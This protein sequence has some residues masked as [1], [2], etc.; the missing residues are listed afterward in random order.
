MVLEQDFNSINMEEFKQKL[1]VLL[2]ELLNKI[3]RDD[4]ILVEPSSSRN[5]VEQSQAGRK[6]K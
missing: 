1:G 5:E 6:V 2:E 3:L 4:Y